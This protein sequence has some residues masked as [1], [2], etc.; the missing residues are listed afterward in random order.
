MCGNKNIFCLWFTLKNI[1]HTYSANKNKPKNKPAK[2]KTDQQAKTKGA[3]LKP[4]FPR[5]LSI[6][7]ED[8]AGQDSEP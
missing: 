7:T 8:C 4:T 6:Q 1:F 3:G 2:I 5:H